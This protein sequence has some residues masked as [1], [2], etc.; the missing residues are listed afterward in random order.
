MTVR[1]LVA[2]GF[3]SLQRVAIAS[4]VGA[5]L[6]GVSLAVLG[7]LALL[8]MAYQGDLDRAR[9]SVGAEV[10]L[11]EWVDDG[12]AGSIAR[13]LESFPEVDAASPRTDSE[14]LALLGLDALPLIPLPRTIRIELSATN[15]TD[16][17]ATGLARSI[18]QRAARISGVDEIAFPDLLVQRVDERSR[19][20]FRV[21]IATGIALALSVVGVVANTAHATVLSRRPVIRTMRLLGAERR[22]IVAPF[23]VQGSVIGLAGGLFA[24]L[25][26]YALG[27]LFPGL[28]GF[29]APGDYRLFLVAFPVA[30]ALLAGLGAL[31][32]TVY[33]VRR[34]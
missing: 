21:V 32:A 10:F 19:L 24:A 23:L 25:L 34:I 14:T 33:Y 5:L 17:D 31:S 22:W 2:E 28:D 7:G 29:I 3:S 9:A 6:S 30:G 1:F 12:R 16:G 20:F 26:L 27:F 4:T 13:E 18:S 15:T 8:A 11:A